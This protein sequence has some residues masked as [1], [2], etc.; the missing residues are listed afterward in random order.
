MVPHQTNGKLRNRQGGA[1]FFDRDLQQ[2][3]VGL[4]GVRVA[5][6]AGP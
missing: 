5:V 1:N 4:G 6:A 3:R 2:A